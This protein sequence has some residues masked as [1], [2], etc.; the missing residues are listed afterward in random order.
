L[1]K[2]SQNKNNEGNEIIDLKSDSEDKTPEKIETKEE[3]TKL[4]DTPD[5]NMEDDGK[6]MSPKEKSKPKL[7]KLSQ[8]TPIIKKKSDSEP[9]ISDVSSIQSCD[10][11]N[12]KS[13]ITKI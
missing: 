10:T 1:I 7:K 8:T 2:N 3:K 4:E 11:A 5:L 9:K 13:N 6:E 12:R